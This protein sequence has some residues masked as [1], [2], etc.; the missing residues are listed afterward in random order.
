[1]FF[2]QTFPAFEFSSPQ[3]EVRQWLPKVHRDNMIQFSQDYI[4]A[5]S[6]LGRQRNQ[7][8][9]PGN[10]RPG[11]E[12]LPTTSSKGDLGLFPV[13]R[14]PPSAYKAQYSHG[15]HGVVMGTQ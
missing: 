9:Q 3:D 4:V 1:M 10:R 8:Q 15:Q 7:G 2:C 11:A 13:L 5:H 14:L 6:A 12:C